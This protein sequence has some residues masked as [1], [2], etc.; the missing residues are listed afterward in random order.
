MTNLCLSD[1]SSGGSEF[2]EEEADASCFYEDLNTPDA[3]ECFEVENLGKTMQSGCKT[4]TI[5]D[6]P[7]GIYKAI[8]IG[9]AGHAPYRKMLKN[10][11]VTL[12]S[13][14]TSGM[15]NNRKPYENE[16]P[17]Q[18][19]RRSFVQWHRIAIYQYR[20]GA[21]AMEYV[22]KGSQVYVE[23]NLETRIFLE[24]ESNSIKR[25]QEIA[26]R[27]NGFVCLSEGNL[28]MPVEHSP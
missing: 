1:V 10:G 13:L 24:P 28:G 3:K 2:S 9:E 16:T 12:F 7:Q 23:G 20:L 4:K 8:L 22:K 5:G 15:R 17:D 6:T 19:T 18:Y 11:A 25:I 26:V 27:Q 21:L 14:G